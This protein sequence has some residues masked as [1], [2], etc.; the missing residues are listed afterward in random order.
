MASFADLKFGP[1]SIGLDGIRA[2]HQFAN[3]Y[4]G[5]VVRFNGS[6]GYAQGLYELAVVHDGELVYDTPI[7][8]DVLGHLTEEDVTAALAQIAALPARA[9]VAA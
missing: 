1:H 4:G 5:S 9:P 3:G 6:Y 7:T 2:R 8:D